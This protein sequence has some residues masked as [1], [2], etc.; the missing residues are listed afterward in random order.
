MKL[1][2]NRMDHQKWLN[3]S[4]T[5]RK[6]EPREL[7]CRD[8]RMMPNMIKSTGVLLRT[9]T[10]GRKTAIAAKKTSAVAAQVTECV[11]MYVKND[12]AATA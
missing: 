10:R 1:T 7:W 3:L 4:G 12:S 11:M 5:S 2:G 6:S 8:E 9:V